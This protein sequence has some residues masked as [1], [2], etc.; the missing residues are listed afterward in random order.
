MANACRQ[1]RPVAARRAICL[2]FWASGFDM[3]V[4][5]SQIPR[6]KVM[7]SLSDSGLATIVLS[8][9]IGAILM[10]PVTGALAT[11]FGG[12]RIVLA[13]GILAAVVLALLGTSGSYKQFLAATFLTGIAI[14]GLD[15]A[16]NTQATVIEQAWRGPIMSGIHGWFSLGG[17]AGAA[18]GGALTEAPMSFQAVLTITAVLTLLAILG[19]AKWLGIAGET[20]NW[21]G[22]AWPRR[23]VLGIG[24]L[25]LLA[26]LIEGAVVD[27]TAVYMHEVGG[28]SLGF[29][30]AGFG[31]FSLSMAV[32]RFAGD[33]I[34]RRIGP[35]GVLAWGASLTA[36]GIA[37]ACAVPHPIVV[38]IGL[39]VAGLGQ[40]NVVPVL[41]SAAGRVPGVA[42]GVGVSM[43]ATMGYGAFL[44]GPPAI[45]FLADG[46]GLRVA[47]LLLVACSLVIAIFARMVKPAPCVGA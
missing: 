17:L 39:T 25:C 37:L 7:L 20:A 16:M 2:V 30:A 28:A 22:I 11:Q 33:A 45:G 44:L 26:F 38:T 12:A 19:S 36:A 29:A 35:A 6:L 46:I 8:F 47:L 40:A 41:F 43:V 5:A 10:M 21:T 4:W 1:T 31:G 32:T 3:G 24:L 15:V 13:M 14:G 18:V 42:P 9:A 23:A 34:T 27:W